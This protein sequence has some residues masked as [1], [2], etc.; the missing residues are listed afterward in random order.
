MTGLALV[1]PIGLPAAARLLV[2]MLVVAM[3]AGCAS[4]PARIGAD[5]ASLAAQ[6][7]REARLDDL[8]EWS[9]TGR[10][11]LAGRSGG[12]NGRIE[13]HQR[14]DDFVIVLSTPVSRQSWRLTRSDGWVRLQGLDDG[15]LEGPDAERLL[16]DA[17][18]WSIPFDQLVYWLLGRRG[19]GPAS[20][21]FAPDGLP[22]LLAQAGWTIDYRDW[23]RDPEP[24]LPAK[25]FA[26]RGQERVRL[27]IERWQRGDPVDRTGSVEA[28]IDLRPDAGRK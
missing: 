8:T 9:L 17:T 28:A 4:R 16:A 18:G 3:M 23:W 22:A 13:W 2:L 10:I 26:H 25:V 15:D 24:A 12:G 1:G 6:S 19:P 5:S 14:G 7:E 11:A 27:L 20:L 21:E